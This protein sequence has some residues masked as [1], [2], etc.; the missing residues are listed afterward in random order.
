[1]RL[2]RT[3]AHE[4]VHREVREKMI[5]FYTENGEESTARE[6][7]CVELVMGK[8]S[9]CASRG[10][11]ELENGEVRVFTIRRPG[12]ENQNGHTRLIGEPMAQ[13]FGVV[14]ANLVRMEA[15]WITD[16]TH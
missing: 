9:Q 1:M 15:D 12:H 2:L 13:P 14:V 16:I 11:V 3:G 4:A 5:S 8:S 10:V 7:Q 6:R